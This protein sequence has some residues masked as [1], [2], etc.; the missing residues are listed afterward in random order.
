[1]SPELLLSAACCLLPAAYWGCGLVDRVKCKHIPLLLRDDEQGVK[2]LIFMC[3]G[4][5][6]VEGLIFVCRGQNDFRIVTRK[7]CC[8]LGSAE[9]SVP[10]ILQADHFLISSTSVQVEL[11]AKGDCCLR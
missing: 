9:G 4:R 3:E 11:H 7:Q 10:G 2:V 1:M 5:L 6:L 8:P